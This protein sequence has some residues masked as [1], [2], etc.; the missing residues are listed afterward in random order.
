MMMS[1]ST[2]SSSSS[3]L[4][5]RTYS[6]LMA[7]RDEKWMAYIFC[8]SDDDSLEKSSAS[9]LTQ[10]QGR[11]LNCSKSRFS[12]R[13]LY[14]NHVDLEVFFEIL[15]EFQSEWRQC[16]LRL[17]SD[18]V[19]LINLFREWVQRW[20]TDN[21]FTNRPNAEMIRNIWLHLQQ[22]SIDLKPLYCNAYSNSLY[23][24]L[25]EKLSRAT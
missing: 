4:S 24:E 18:N 8:S 25:H 15:K 6:V 1:S 14:R 11:L 17:Y 3:S 19:Y 12:N 21:S 2:S 7:S 23:R 13:F 5:P 9:L 20:Q 10:L 16:T 22:Q